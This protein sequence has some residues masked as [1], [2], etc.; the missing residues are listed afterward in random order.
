[1]SEA[2]AGVVSSRSSADGGYWVSS[3]TGDGDERQAAMW[4]AAGDAGPVLNAGVGSGLA[5]GSVT[6]VGD[7]RKSG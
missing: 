2:M 5:E 4:W 7:G 6:A 1:M 3:E